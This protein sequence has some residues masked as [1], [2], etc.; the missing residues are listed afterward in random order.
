[1]RVVGVLLAL[2]LGAG[3]C[4]SSGGGGPQRPADV[5]IAIQGYRFLPPTVTVR[6]GATIRFLNRDAVAHTATANFG[7]FDT[8]D[9]KPGQSKTFTVGTIG[10]AAYHC[11]IH[12]RMTGQLVIVQ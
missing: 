12:P 9:L 3:G 10:T 1:M 6:V 11:S 8:G 7:G 2:A 5:T 4:G